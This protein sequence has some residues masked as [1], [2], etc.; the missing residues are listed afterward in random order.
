MVLHCFGRMS[1]EEKAYL[2]DT[3]WARVFLEA[4]IFTA[5]HLAVIGT[6]V[7]SW[8]LLPMMLVGVLPTMYGAWLGVY[9]GYT[10]H[11]GLAEDVLDHRL[12]T[13][14]VY[15]NPVFRFTYW[16]MNYHVEHHLFPMVPYHQLPKLHALVKADTPPPYR[17][18]I[19]A[20]AEIIPTVLRQ[21]RDPAYYVRRPLP[22][23]AEPNGPSV[24]RAAE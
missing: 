14:T 13:R 16:N 6:A 8:S 10:Q 4:R 24:A 11:I 23:A 18:T 5:I 9:V 19:A 20:Y 15:M 21:R 2:P 7:A 22:G 1:A 3:E 12:N 17:S